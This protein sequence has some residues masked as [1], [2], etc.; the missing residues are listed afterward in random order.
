MSKGSCLDLISAH[1]GIRRLS[2]KLINFEHYS[3]NLKVLR[4]TLEVLGEA[5]HSHS[6]NFNIFQS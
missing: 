1:A 6:V 3:L 4:S 2:V 5:Q